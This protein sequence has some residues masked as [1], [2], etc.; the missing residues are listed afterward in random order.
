[1]NVAKRSTDPLF[2]LMRAV[3]RG[4]IFDARKVSKLVNVQCP[5]CRNTFDSSLSHSAVP[6]RLG[7]LGQMHSASQ[8]TYGLDDTDLVLQETNGNPGIQW[9]PRSRRNLLAVTAF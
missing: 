3:T 8:K 5:Q 7:A 1:M 9:M 6:A 2:A 4:L